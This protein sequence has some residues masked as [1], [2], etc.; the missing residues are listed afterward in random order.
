MASDTYTVA[1]GALQQTLIKPYRLK[2]NWHTINTNY[3][4]I[5]AEFNQQYTTLTSLASRVSAVEAP[6]ITSNSYPF[7]TGTSFP[8]TGSSSGTALDISIDFIDRL[9]VFN[10]SPSRDYFISEIQEIVTPV[11]SLKVTISSKYGATTTEVCSVTITKTQTDA[12]T[13]EF[14]FSE[15][16][17]SGVYGG[18]GIGDDFITAVGAITASNTTTYSYSVSK[19]NPTFV[20]YTF[21]AS[22]EAEAGVHMHRVLELPVGSQNGSNRTFTAPYG[23]EWETDSI[24]VY[25]NG[26]AYSPL[27]ITSKTSTTFTLGSSVGSSRL[28]D[29]SQARELRVSYMVWVGTEVSPLASSGQR[30]YQHFASLASSATEDISHK[31]DPAMRRLIEVYTLHAGGNSDGVIKVE[32]NADTA[33]NYNIVDPPFSTS[34]NGVVDEYGAH[35][36]DVSNEYYATAAVSNEPIDVSEV[37]KI[38]GVSVDA[39]IPS[40]TYIRWFARF[41]NSGDFYTHNGTNWAITSTADCQNGMT[42]AELEALS[43]S[44]WESANG[45]NAGVTSYLQL[46][47]YMSTSN[48]LYTPYLQSYSVSNEWDG[49]WI[50]D[51]Q[52]NSIRVS[53]IDEDTTRIA[54]T[55]ASNEYTLTNIFIAE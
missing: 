53:I 42:T 34:T 19:I 12:G 52:R 23:D 22:E 31:A 18:I 9:F 27:E 54:N 29:A 11:K 51:D 17:D 43:Q 6:I 55:S 13:R 35:L 49:T 47:P 37:T 21:V 44:D 24:A 16:N 14:A 41:S 25:L 28:P 38:Y 26:V 50:K 5:A 8:I 7:M 3:D 33:D 32:F 20:Q 48:D 30:F 2:F 40:S 4:A 39:S 46:L 15:I 36:A 1:F 45:F 10:A